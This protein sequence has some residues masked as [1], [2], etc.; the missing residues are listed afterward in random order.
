MSDE[1]KIAVYLSRLDW[2]AVDLCLKHHID[3]ITIDGKTLWRIGWQRTAYIRECISK[4]LDQRAK[5][6]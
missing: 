5:V 1:R 2:Q 3:S 4:K 6:E